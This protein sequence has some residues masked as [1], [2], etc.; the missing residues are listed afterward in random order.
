LV[1]FL[2][3]SYPSACCALE[4][5]VDRTLRTS[6]SL[7]Q[8]KKHTTANLFQ[9]QKGTSEEARIIGGTNAALGQY[10]FYG[11]SVKDV[12]HVQ[13]ARLDQPCCINRI[14]IF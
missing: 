8:H 14:N 1:A 2:V 10:P 5:L 13:D 9:N 12:L 7:R 4:Q 6:H 11:T 3:F